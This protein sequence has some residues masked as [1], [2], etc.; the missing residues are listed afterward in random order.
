MKLGPFCLNESVVTL[1]KKTCFTSGQEG[2]RM[3]RRGEWEPCIQSRLLFSYRRD[4]VPLWNTVMEK[5][6]A[7]ENLTLRMGCKSLMA[8]ILTRQQVKKEEDEES[9]NLSFLDVKCKIFH[10]T[11]S[12]RKCRGAET[13]ASR[14]LCILPLPMSC[15]RC[16][17][18]SVR[19][20]ANGEFRNLK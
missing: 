6:N 19:N 1:L 5:L 10:S 11:S 12:I 13:E 4:S 16:W 9:G 15:S 18:R 17:K 3:G 7:K 14:K 8:F 20:R 2:V